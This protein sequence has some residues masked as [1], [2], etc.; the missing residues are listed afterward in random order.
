MSSHWGAKPA[1]RGRRKAVAGKARSP[2]RLTGA[3]AG[4]REGAKPL[5]ERR[6]PGDW[7]GAKPAAPDWRLGRDLRDLRDLREVPG[8]ALRTRNRLAGFAPANGVA[9]QHLLCTGEWR[10]AQ[11][12][13]LPPPGGLGGPGGPGPPAIQ[14]NPLRAARPPPVAPSCGR[15][16]HSQRQSPPL[17][18]TWR[19][20]FGFLKFP[21]ADGA[22]MAY[23]F[24]RQPFQEDVR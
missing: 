5:A 6:E 9:R 2:L 20:I 15:P 13:P 21:L 10:G 4:G 8:V 22:E 12:R 18:G 7:E 23:N 16:V 14:W 3:W 24:R 11:A 1:A 17:A 19:A